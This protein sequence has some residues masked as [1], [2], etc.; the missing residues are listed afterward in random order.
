MQ[1]VFNIDFEDLMKNK[2]T[3]GRLKDLADVEQLMKNKK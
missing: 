1:N 2:I 3:T